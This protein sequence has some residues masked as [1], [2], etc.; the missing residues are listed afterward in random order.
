MKVT[1]GYYAKIENLK[2]K[3]DAAEGNYKAAIQGAITYSQS[4]NKGRKSSSGH[5][6]N[7]A[8]FWVWLNNTRIGKVNLNN[9]GD[10][11]GGKDLVP[12]AVAG[13]REQTVIVKDNVAARIA[14]ADKQG[15]VTFYLEPISTDAH[16][17]VPWIRIE[18]EKGK[19]S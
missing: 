13:S 9:A 15:S 6:C 18:T 10:N 11:A 3:L 2:K 19:E 8:V 5:Q 1:V 16:N 7:R 4:L 14:K 12:G 17:D